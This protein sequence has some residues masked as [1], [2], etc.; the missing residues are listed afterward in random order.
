MYILGMLDKFNKVL[1]KIVSKLITRSPVTMEVA[2]SWNASGEVVELSLK[3]IEQNP[4]KEK[5]LFRSFLFEPKPNF[6][7]T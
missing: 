2:P 7:T 3:S 4:K 1:I 5:Y 6:L